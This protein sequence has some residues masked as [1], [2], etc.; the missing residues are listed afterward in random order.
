MANQQPVTKIYELKTIGVDNVVSDFNKVSAVIEKLKKA[1][2]ELNKLLSQTD[3]SKIVQDTTQKLDA[4]TR[5]QAETVASSARAYSQLTSEYKKAKQNAEDMAAQF[6][7]ESQQAK[8]AAVQLADYKAQLTAINNLVKNAGKPEVVP[9]TSSIGNAQLS[10]E[11]LRVAQ[12]TGV[13]VSELEIKEA[14]AANAATAWV[15]S[16]VL[17]KDAIVGLGEE[18]ERV[19]IPLEQYTGTLDANIK[20]NIQYKTRLQEI[21]ASM[22]QLQVAYKASGVDAEYYK[23]KMASLAKEEKELKIASSELGQTISA[24]IKYTQAAEGSYDQLNATLGLSRNLLRQMTEEEKASPFGL[25]LAKDIDKLDK[26]LK[27]MDASIGNHQRHVGDYARGYSGLNMSIQQILREAPSAAVSL[28]TFFLAISN[29]L[30]ILFD[31]LARTKQAIEAN[32]LAAKEGA[33]AARLQAEAAAIQA[34]ATKEAA[35]AEGLLAEKTALAN[36]QQTKAPSLIKQITSSLF[37]FQSYLTIGVLLLT[38]YGGK[39]IEWVKEMVKG[40]NT[41]D[42]VAAKQKL[43]NEVMSSANKEAAKQIVDL[44]TLYDVAT[45]VNVVM[46][47]RLDAVKALQKQFPETFAQIEKE[48][49]LNGEAKKS[50]EELTT[51]IIN[52]SKARAAK[53]KL[54]EIESQRLDLDSQKD[55]INKVVAYEKRNAKDKNLGSEGG[56]FEKGTGTKSVIYTKEQQQADAEARRKRA[57]A[58]IDDKDK[59]LKRQE[60]FLVKFAGGQS[61][62]AEIIENPDKDKN[63]GKSKIDRL[64]AEMQNELKLIEANRQRL[65]SVENKNANEIEKVRK[66]T[67]DEEI[68]HL[69]KI[70]QINVTALNAKIDIFNK[71]KKLNAEEKLTKAQFDEELSSLELQTSKKIQDIEKRRY[72]DQEKELQVHL[73]NMSKAIK[74]RNQLVQDDPNATAQVKAAAQ[75][76]ADNEI[77]AAEKEYY[78]ALLKLNSDYNKEEIIK[79]QERIDAIKKVIE[80]DRKEAALAELKDLQTQSE[81]RLK[82]YD[83]N[84]NLARKK[85]LDNDKLTAEQKAIQLEQLDRANK[86]T[87]LSEELNTLIAQLK[88]KKALLD[89]SLISNADYL[90]A[91]DEIS[92]KGAELSA[93]SDSNLKPLEER[94]QSAG[95]KLR[96]IISKALGFKDGGIKDQFV[97]EFI[98]QSFS[99]AKDAMNGYFDSERQRIQESLKL[100]EDRIEIERNQR[101]GQAQSRAEEASIN[102]QADQKKRAAQI[103]AG[104]EIKKSKKAEARINLATELTGIAVQASQYPFPFSLAIGSFLTALALGRYA[105]QIGSINAQK[106]ATGGRVQPLK[107]GKITSRPNIP[108]QPNGDSVLATVRPGEVI[109]NEFQQALLGGSKTFK[110]IGVPGFANGGVTGRYLGDVLQPPVF[111]PTI[112]NVIVNNSGDAELLE[113][114]K[115][116]RH[117]NKRLADETSNRIDRVEVVQVTSSV[118][119][120]QK[121]AVKQNDIGTL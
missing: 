13:A 75:L 110:S 65:L 3:D 99:L 34:G 10:E 43:L 60:D 82:V 29:N 120:A 100:A 47:K 66:M 32:T 45:D 97:G 69:Q 109:L 107:N 56:G 41:I 1:K 33:A 21:S 30:P 59:T 8:E 94:I 117:E 121:K 17:G 50:Y 112:S 57:L 37:S 25:Q 7:V 24:Q 89:L 18:L 14:E 93:A 104:E 91:L 39:I 26:S 83:I 98:S 55:L 95:E 108:V 80:K 119:N 6:G 114:I 44:R 42:E 111:L 28:N 118:T 2:I 53:A 101:L 64:S 20:L 58:D 86:R 70:E 92:K 12:A 38:L 67:F 9:G 22:K 79:T 52:A 19:K 36:A 78:E 88:V 96:G 115:Q 46:A 90:K 54:D 40:K 76:E 23:G 68:D 106:F 61:K 102:R 49:I 16:Q 35:I 81:N 27:K 11:Q 116:L 71:K 73:D 31:E 103:K 87:I 84:Y 5:K 113:E 63:K 15:N 48:K 4:I 72:A 62:I 77:L 105:V 74:D 85:I 51:A